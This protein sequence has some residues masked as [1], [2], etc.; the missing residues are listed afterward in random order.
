[1]IFV[2]VVLNGNKVGDLVVSESLRPLFDNRF[3]EFAPGFAQRPDGSLDL[4]EISIV[5]RSST[6]GEQMDAQENR[7]PAVS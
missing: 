1:M 5:Y 7:L 2:P 4:K 6:A 3:V